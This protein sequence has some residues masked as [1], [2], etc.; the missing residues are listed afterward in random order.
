MQLD[1]NFNIPDAETIASE[2]LQ[3]ALDLCDEFQEFAVIPKIDKSGRKEK[4]RPK[5]PNVTDQGSAS[6]KAKS[7]SESIQLGK[8]DTLTKQGKQLKKFGDQKFQ[9]N[10]KKRALCDYA[11]AGVRFYEA[12]IAM[13]R[14]GHKTS[15]RALFNQNGNFL[16]GCAAKTQKSFPIL[17]SIL[18]YF[19]ALCFGRAFK[20][21]PQDKKF[22]D[23][24]KA[25]ITRTNEK[26]ETDAVFIKHL[27]EYSND[28]YKAMDCYR[29]AKARAN[30]EVK[31]PKNI[32]MMSAT[33]ILQFME[34]HLKKAASNSE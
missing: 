32:L 2:S 15:A 33:D 5:R 9:E 6:K 25:A 21:S 18:Y 19:A 20:L 7:E 11:Y 3:K 22:R 34:P 13:K 23:Q 4:K 17:E 27:L 10:K 1:L 29:F 14:S 24:H 26:K 16:L 12:A 30:K 8:V 28:M 31:F